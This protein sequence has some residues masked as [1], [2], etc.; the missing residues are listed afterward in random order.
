M[1]RVNELRKKG[2]RIGDNTVIYSDD[3]SIDT[4]TPWLIEIGDNVKITKGVKILTH[5]Y[6]WCVLK[7]LYGDVLGSR[8]KVKIGNNVFIG[9]GTT[10]LKNVS[11]G[12]NSIIAAGSVVCSGNYPENS[13]IA[14]VP[15]KVI[16]GLEDYY[17]KRMEVQLKEAKELAVE[18][19]KVT[20]SIPP[21]TIFREF[22]WLFE[23][24]GDLPKEFLDVQALGGNLE[25]SMKRFM[26][27]KPLFNSYEE[28]IDYCYKDS[29]N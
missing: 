4:Q 15:A 13:I 11:I 28:F 8:G 14:G 6:D 17:K 18:Y 20:N 3:V 26:E 24:R 9:M 21:K 16:G 19:K 23:K 10:I 12:N 5:G 27:T 25:K 1:Q 7:T 22:F 2:C 29:D